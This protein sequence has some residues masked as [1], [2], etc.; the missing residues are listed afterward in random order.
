MDQ[1]LK[2]LES[3]LSCSGQ[4]NKLTMEIARQQKIN[5]NGSGEKQE[6]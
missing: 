5:T 1:L 3:N 4:I 6:S 2:R